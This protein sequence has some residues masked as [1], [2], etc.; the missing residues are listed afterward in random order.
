MTHIQAI[1]PY[2]LM[3]MAGMNFHMATI[4]LESPHWRL[5]WRPLSLC[6]V[7]LL[8]VIGTKQFRDEPRPSAAPVKV[9]SVDSPYA[10]PSEGK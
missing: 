1:L 10:K 9:E 4:F 2:L 3:F 7:C 8:T 6:A 5:A